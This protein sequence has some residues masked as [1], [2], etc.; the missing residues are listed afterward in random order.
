MWELPKSVAHISMQ[1]IMGGDITVEGEPGKGSMFTVR[2]PTGAP[3]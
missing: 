3:S 2:L 1:Q